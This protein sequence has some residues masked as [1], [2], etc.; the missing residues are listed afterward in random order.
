MK[1]YEYAY[2]VEPFEIKNDDDV[3]TAMFKREKILEMA[4]ANL[5]V[6]DWEFYQ[7]RDIKFNE[8]KKE[9][10]LITAVK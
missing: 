2:D 6:V 8:F 3:E 4:K 5:N 7:K 10:D 1:T 9:F